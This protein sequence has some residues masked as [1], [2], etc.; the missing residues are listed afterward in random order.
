MT[1]LL[2]P[3]TQ[4]VNTINGY[5]M[6][7]GTNWVLTKDG[8]YRLEG[9]ALVHWQ[10]GHYAVELVRGRTQIPFAV[11]KAASLLANAY[12]NLSDAQ[13]S[14][15]EQASRGDISYRMR[16]SQLIAPEAETWLGVYRNAVGGALV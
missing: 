12:L 8:L 15:F 7:T 11:L 14:Q 3:D 13:R 10:P 5:P 6:P 4:S 2:P 16:F 9:G 1:L